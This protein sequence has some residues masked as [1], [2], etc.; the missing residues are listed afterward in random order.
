MTPARG[1]LLVALSVPCLSCGQ[2][3][4]VTAAR[5]LTVGPDSALVHFDGR[6]AAAAVQHIAPGA[7]A[8]ANVQIWFGR[9]LMAPDTA[10]TAVAVAV[11]SH[12][13]WERVFGQPN[14]I[15]KT[16]TVNGR[17]FVVVGIVQPPSPHQ[18]A[19]QVWLPPPR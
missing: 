12:A 3:A 15:G 1:F 6:D 11:I 17:T 7:A 4:P 5:P 14:I 13:L 19:V 2:P 8:M 16:I 9:T 18:A 10:R